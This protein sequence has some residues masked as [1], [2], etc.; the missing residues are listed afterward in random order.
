MFTN[1]LSIYTVGVPCYYVPD[2]LLNCDQGDT[3]KDKRQ[4]LGRPDAENHPKLKSIDLGKQSA[5]LQTG[6]SGKLEESRPLLLSDKD[7]IFSVGKSTDGGSL[8]AP[9]MRRTGQKEGSRVVFGV[10]KP[11]KKRK[12]MEVSKH[13][14][15]G[16]IENASEGSDGPKNVRYL[17]PQTSGAWKNASKVE[18]KGRKGGE[19]KPK[20][21]R[22]VKPQSSQT[23]VATER[24]GPVLSSALAANLGVAMPAARASGSLVEQ[25]EKSISGPETFTSTLGAEDSGV[26]E[27]SM[28][29]V[30]AIPAASKKKAMTSGESV[31]TKG[32]TASALERAK[33]EERYGSVSDQTGKLSADAGEL[34]R[35]NRRIQ[36]TSRVSPA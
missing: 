13:Y 31:G 36:P 29:H 10:P 25:S 30:A 33:S 7:K 4:K 21:I 32:K 20:V 19:P 16:K 12:F 34:R 22:P 24:E 3:P 9:K 11:G 17:P 1:P 35:S 2:F 8:N 6:I 27:S 14:V 18:T 28:Q 26:L 15:T 5:N 23:R